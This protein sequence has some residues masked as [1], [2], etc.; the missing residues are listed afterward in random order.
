MVETDNAIELKIER[1]FNAPLEMVWK[2]WTEPERLKDWN[3]PN[4]FRPKFAEGEIKTGEAYRVGWMAPW[5]EE[6]VLRGT[7]REV[8]PMDRLVF[9]HQWEEDDGTFTVETLITI[10]FSG[11]GDK[12]LMTFT[13]SGFASVESRDRHREGWG[14][15]VDKLGFYLQAQQEPTIEIVRVFDAPRELVFKVWTDPEHVTNWWG[16]KGYSAPIIKSDVRVGGV[17]MYSMQGPKGEVNWNRGVFEEIVPPERVVTVMTFADE[18]GNIKSP[19]DYG[20]EGYPV[21]MRDV[22]TFETVEG[23]KTRLTIRRGT[24]VSISKKFGEEEGWN[25]S[26]DKLAEELA[27]IQK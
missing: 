19:A 24:P 4:G 15:C 6:I 20:M 8:T 26:L 16:P 12:T 25:S 10:E 14:Q 7:Y 23:N 1:E 21:E 13:Q 9:T 3:R 22:V 2:A 18:E 5:D 11:Q 17:F 27:R